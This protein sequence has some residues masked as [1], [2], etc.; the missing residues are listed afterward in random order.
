MGTTAR[1]YF[2]FMQGKLYKKGWD[3][4]TWLISEKIAK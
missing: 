3:V 4:A 1:T 2:I